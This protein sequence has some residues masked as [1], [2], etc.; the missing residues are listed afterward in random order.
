MQGTTLVTHVLRV[1][2]SSE[3]RDLERELHSFWSI[4]S[5]GIIENE[6][7]VQA[8]FEEH[9]SF[10]DGRYVVSLPWKDSGLSLPDNYELSL[11]RLNAC[12]RGLKE[13]LSY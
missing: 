4:E 10:V 13:I 5:M 2:S 1:E 11:R 12:I 8:Q 9:V 3:A 7:V 6:S